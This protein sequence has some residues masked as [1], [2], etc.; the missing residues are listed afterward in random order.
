MR[1]CLCVF[2]GLL[3][4]TVLLDSQPLSRVLGYF[5]EDFFRAHAMG[6]PRISPDGKQVFY[7]TSGQ[8]HNRI[9]LYDVATGETSILHRS[10]S[11]D[12]MFTAAAWAG[13][14]RFV[15]QVD[16]G[17][18]YV[19]TTSQRS[20]KQI[21]DARRTFIGYG[22]LIAGDFGRAELFAPLYDQE[23]EILLSTSDN[24]G[25]MEILRVNLETAE[26]TTEQR[27]RHHIDQWI[28]TQTGEVYAGVRYRRSEIEFRYRPPGA[29]LWRSLD[30]FAPEQEQGFSYSGSTDASRRLQ[31]L[32]F[33][34]SE[35]E[36]FYVANTETDTRAL[37][38]MDLDDRTQE[39]IAHNPDYDLF[40]GGAPGERL[41]FSH[42]DKQIAGIHYHAER[43]RTL[44]FVERFQRTQQRID[45]KLPDTVNTIH[46]FDHSGQHFVI[47]AQSST[48]KGA[49]YL[50]HSEPNELIPL[51]S[52]DSRV[53]PDDLSPMRPIAFEARDGHQLH[54]YLTLPNGA[55]EADSSVPLVVL[56]H[57]GPWIRD[58]YGYDP[59]VQ[60][61]AYNG[62]A[63]LQ[64]NFRG[65]AGYGF[66]HFDAIR[67]RFGQTAV[68]DIED[69]VDWSTRAYPQLDPDAIALMGSSYGAYAAMNLLISNPDT[70]Q[71][72]VLLMGLYDLEKHAQFLQ[73]EVSNNF[74]ID[75]WN[76]MVGNV[77]E[78]E[79]LSRISP[80]HDIAELNTPVFVAHGE[81]DRI[82]P[83]EQ[84]RNLISE[85]EKHSLPHQSYFMSAEGHGIYE[86]REIIAVY[87]R[88][89]DFLEDTTN[90]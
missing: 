90:P 85:L 79:S 68:E 15:F 52:V 72:G 81:Q 18:W 76:E 89:L 25:R 11:S 73:D 50:Y 46:D 87:S 42:S 82:V 7:F 47:N 51:G 36:I 20:I 38:R 26:T 30:Y 57:G 23:D 43:P 74:A 6:P 5:P 21:F 53:S 80:I 65:S 83:V 4:G 75:F 41:I 84:S 63:V 19:A 28:P 66:E 29:W 78:P 39:R 10:D 17:N 44:W 61:L 69:A 71:G 35:S 24:R 48:H 45:S 12:E 13:N 40:S 55:G 9:Q 37:Y 22:V 60:L 62:Y 54:G 2:F 32:S 67:R 33:G 3:A 70:F 56:I 27:S 58:T 88:I 77:W 64:V 1:V 31:F 16:H 34:F 86:S 59:E 49:Y 8:N 14:E